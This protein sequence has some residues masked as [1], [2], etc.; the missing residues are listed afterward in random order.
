MNY[1]LTPCFGILNHLVCQVFDTAN[2]G[3]F[4]AGAFCIMLLLGSICAI[5]VSTGLA[6]PEALNNLM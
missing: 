5:V 3:Y 1:I 6:V 2:L 4:A